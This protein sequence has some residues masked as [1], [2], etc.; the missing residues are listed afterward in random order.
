[1]EQGNLSAPFTTVMNWTSIS[2]QEYE[3]RV[4][5]QKDREFEPFFSLPRDTGELMEMAVNAPAKVH[6][7]LTQGGWRLANPREITRSPWT[8]QRYLKNSRAE[9][10]VA[11]HG[12][13]ST[14]CGWFSDR[15]SAYLATGRPVIIQDTGFSSFLP[16]G[17]GLLAYS[18][19]DEATAAIQQLRKDYDMHCRAAREV[20]EE[21]FDARKVL[22]DLLERIV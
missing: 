16:C 19:R 1:V 14:R 6:E 8:Y 22:N 3:G 2:D 5:G 15:S 18:T 17:K 12:Y 7:R 9:F 13:V 20:A 4:Y 21:F 11:K 10:C